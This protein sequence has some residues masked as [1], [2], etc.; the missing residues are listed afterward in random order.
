MECETDPSGR[1]AKAAIQPLD[2]SQVAYLKATEAVP[3]L[4]SLCVQLLS[5]SEPLGS[6]RTSIVV[7]VDQSITIQFLLHQ[8]ISIAD[9]LP[10]FCTQVQS[11]D[12][13]V[14]VRHAWVLSGE[15]IIT[16]HSDSNSLSVCKSNWHNQQQCIL[17]RKGETTLYSRL[18]MEIVGLYWNVPV[19]RRVLAAS[20]QWPRV[21]LYGLYA[22]GLR[23]SLRAGSSTPRQLS[24]PKSESYTL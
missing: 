10:A 13:L 16:L 21:T 7:D 12:Y 24:F 18:K 11:I 2:P 5:L 20:T 1:R 6:K 22:A 3:S 15:M 4:P 23:S 9:I 19:R 17:D 14:V 8:T